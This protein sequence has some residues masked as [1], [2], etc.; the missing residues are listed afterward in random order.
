VAGHR[1]TT[2]KPLRLVVRVDARAAKW[3]SR[4]AAAPTWV[5]RVGPAADHVDGALVD[6]AKIDPAAAEAQAEQLVRALMEIAT[7]ID[8]T[9]KRRPRR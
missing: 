5:Q 1:K 6:L 4:I 9:V 8:K 7:G 2:G 3:R